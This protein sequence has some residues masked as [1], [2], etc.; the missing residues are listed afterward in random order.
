[1]RKIDF[2][3]LLTVVVPIYNELD[4]IETL[5]S[6]VRQTFAGLDFPGR[7]EVILVNDGSTDGSAEKLDAIAHAFPEHIKVVHLARNFGHSQAVRAG[8]DLAK[9]D[10]VIVM[11]G[12]LQ[13]DPAAFGPFLQ[14]WIEGYDVVYAVRTSR[15]ERYGVPLL[16]KA[17]Y[18]VMSHV[19]EV[20]IPQDAGNFS[21]MDRRVINQLSAL[22]ERSRYLPGL[23]A[24]VGFRQVGVPVPRRSRYDDSTR[25]GYRGLLK[26]A[27]NAI[28]SFSHAPLTLFRMLGAIAVVFSVALISYACYGKFITGEAIKAWMSQFVTITF[29]GGVNLLGVGIIGE[30]VV[31]IYDEVKKRPAYVIDQITSGGHRRRFEAIDPSRTTVSAEDT[32]EADMILVRPSAL[33]RHG[34]LAPAE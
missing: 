10:A 33:R 11:D 1:M 20:Q 13:D 34:V 18:R 30:Y 8:L 31:R 16:F 3:T 23:R 14:K 9:G 26:L 25:V 32:R 4:V 24:W 21:L 17:F 29:F 6:E 2:E 7:Y 5:V 28:F 27:N 12:D 15:Q 19:S 22:P